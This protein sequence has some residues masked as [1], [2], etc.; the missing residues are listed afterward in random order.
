MRRAPVPIFTNLSIWTNSNSWSC[1][2][3]C[4]GQ[5][6]RGFHQPGS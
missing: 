2:L 3:N 5:V 6:F 1:S 4:T